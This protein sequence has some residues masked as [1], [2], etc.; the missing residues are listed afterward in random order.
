MRSSR[1]S[2]ATLSD[3]ARLATGSA[4]G[5]SARARPALA[6]RRDRRL[7]LA[8]DR[9]HRDARLRRAPRSEMSSEYAYA[10]LSPIDRAH[11]DAAVDVERARLDDA[12]LE[13]PALEARVLEVEVGE[14]DVVR[15]GSSA[16]TRDSAAGRGRAGRAAGARRRR[17]ATA[18]T[19]GTERSVTGIRTVR[20]A[21]GV[22]SRRAGVDTPCNCGPCRPGSTTHERLPPSPCP[23]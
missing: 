2:S 17:G 12:F 14:I 8:A 15:R 23:R 16:S 9:A 11:A 6:E 4:S 10:C 21:G 5:Y 18:A 19:G 3:S 20:G 7:P 1:S 22:A 13:A